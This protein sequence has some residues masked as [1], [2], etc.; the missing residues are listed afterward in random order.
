MPYE[1]DQ[2][3]R[4][5]GEKPHQKGCQAVAEPLLHVVPIVRPHLPAS[6][7]RPFQGSHLIHDV[8]TGDD[9]P[10]ARDVLDRGRR[11][12]ILRNRAL[13]SMSG[14]R[15][16]S[17]DTARCRPGAKGLLKAITRL[18]QPSHP[19]RLHRIIMLMHISLLHPVVGNPKDLRQEVKNRPF[20]AHVPVSPPA[21]PLLC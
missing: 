20:E 9:G 16:L 6:R 4:S 14:P 19:V 21:L 15:P 12:A 5:K 10:S 17:G 11:D 8:D 2:S 7:P 3:L 1:H 18:L 13:A